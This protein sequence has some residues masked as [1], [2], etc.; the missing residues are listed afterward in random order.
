[1]NSGWCLLYGLARKKQLV[2]IFWAV[3]LVHDYLLEDLLVLEL[4][5]H[6]AVFGPLLICSVSTLLLSG[7]L[8]WLEKSS[9]ATFTF[10]WYMKLR[11]AIRAMY[12][13]S[14]RYSTAPR[15]AHTDSSIE[16]LERIA[17]KQ[18]G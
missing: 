15:S 4:L 8:Q 3:G 6:A 16:L 18:T 10:P 2:E 1:M 7:P 17:S 12:L 13:K 9:C 14:F 5:M 11:T